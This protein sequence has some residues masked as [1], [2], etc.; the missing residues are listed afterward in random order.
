MSFAHMRVWAVFFAFL[1]LN[2][3]GQRYTSTWYNID[4]GLPQ[5]SAKAIAKDKYGFIW[6][7]TENGLVRYDGISFVTFN[8]FKIDNLHFGMF[9]GDPVRDSITTLTNFQENKIIIKNR[10]PRLSKLT[11]GDRVSYTKGNQLVQ[12]IANNTIS[13]NFYND[14]QY[15]IQ[16]KS[17]K[18]I[19]REKDAVIYKNERGIETRISLPFTNE[20]LNSIFVLNE[21]L[22]INDFQTR[23]TYSIHH[24]KLS[25]YDQP[26]LFNDPET[27]IYW[28]QITNQSFII[29]R[30]NI[31]IVEESPNGPSLKF[32][33]KYKEIGSHSYYSMYYGK[34][35]NNLYL[36]TLNNGLNILHLS[37]M[38]VARKEADFAN[39]VSNASLPFSNNTIITE[40]GTE[41]GKNGIVHKYAFGNNDNYL[42]MYD[43]SGNILIRKRKSIIRFYKNSG[44][45]KKDSTYIKE[46]FEDFMKSG[47]LYALSLLNSSRYQLQIFKKDQFTKPDYIYSFKSPVTA[48]FQYSEGHVLVG[49]N[50]GLYSL[51][52]DKNT[53]RPLIKNI[54]VKSIV[55][56]KDNLIW[57]MTNKNGFYLFKDR[58]LVKMP[59]DRN[60]YLQSAHSI[61]ED[62]QGFYWISSNNGLYKVPKKQLIQYAENRKS[63]V[64]YYRFTKKDGFTSNEFNGNSQ[65]N[66][67]ALE[68][69]E[70]IFPSMDGFVFFNPAQVQTYYPDPK[71]I[72]IERAKIGNAE[73]VYF[74]TVLDLKNDYKTADIF[75]DI[76]YFSNFENLYIEAK[77]S[78]EE[79]SDWEAVALGKDLKYTISN[80]SPGDYTLKV[81][82]LA[83]PDGKYEEKAVQFRIE[84]YFFQ[85]LLFKILLSIIFLTGIII[86]IMLMTNLL[87]TKN[88]ALKRIV[89]NKNSKLKETSLTLEVVK[90]DLQKETE[91][92]KKLVETISHDITTPIRFIAMLSQKLHESDD[93]ELQKKY[94]DSIY[95][96]SEQLYQFT[97]NLKEY[98][99][100][101]KAENIFE[102]QEYPVNRILE[103]KKKLFWEI[104]KERETVI[105]NS[106]ETN[107]NSRVSESILSAIIHNVIDNAVKNTFKGEISLNI[108]EDDQKII[109]IIDDTGTGMSTEQIAIYMNLFKNPK[110][111]TPSFKGK[112]L[113]LHMVIHLV[114][115]INAE[116]SFSQNFPK[117]TIVEITLKKN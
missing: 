45:K 47:N 54:S 116:I 51:M 25:V 29:N 5:S 65:P 58:K 78:G 7:S 92:Q 52:L 39:N 64:F 9:I 13:S 101:Y 11:P 98:T 59:N 32:L 42:M 36:G 85:T 27:K 55:K 28:Q 40:D 99:E 76:P 4:N 50:E 109:I 18:Y 38:Y 43:N 115:K 69:G 91:Y 86:I 94:F 60:N 71:K 113:G 56:T 88:K 31:Y 63:P 108:I 110:W 1:Y 44:Y 112:G 6:I 83:S 103:I 79:E 21:T 46:G 104:A 12:R 53:V 66:A 89:H 19:F 81:R 17:S 41:F 16:L 70:F 68:N 111:K 35:F 3:Y 15:F 62:Q 48:F 20:D 23:K 100:L 97:L 22:F 87:R 33:V 14:V 90:N 96:S 105:I 75:I 26:S 73:T 57:I 93:V 117:G 77:I 30:N 8:N 84:P 80:L 114:K 72:Y 106:T 95:K 2:I 37:N 49:N 61:L 74:N 34:N 82:I 107:I 24:G 67:Y 10:F 102:E